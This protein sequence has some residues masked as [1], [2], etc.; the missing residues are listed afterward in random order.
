MATKNESKTDKTSEMKPKRAS[1]SKRTHVRRLKQEARKT[2]GIT[3]A[4]VYRPHSSLPQ[5]AEAN[6]PRPMDAAGECLL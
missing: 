5:V 2:A 1:K 3:P 4:H 6:T